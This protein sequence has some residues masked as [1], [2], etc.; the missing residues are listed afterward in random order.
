MENLKKPSVLLNLLLILIILFLL[1]KACNGV[2]DMTTVPPGDKELD[3]ILEASIENLKKNNIISLNEAKEMKENYIINRIR[4]FKGQL[5]EMYGQGFKETQNVW[6]HIDT[7]ET[8]LSY[9]KQKS[10]NV[11]GLIFYY[12]VKPSGKSK[13]HQTFFIAPTKQNGDN[14]YGFTIIG[15][16]EVFLKDEFGI[17]EEIEQKTE[18]AGFF[19]YSSSLQE[20]SLL[21]NRGSGSPP[22]NNQ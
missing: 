22:D 19:S 21:L 11:E 2:D 20:E 6:F 14:Q 7:I 1:P 9:L 3:S 4:P 15:G 13:N 8:Y 17:Y 16:N 12:G 5:E 18:E 10:K